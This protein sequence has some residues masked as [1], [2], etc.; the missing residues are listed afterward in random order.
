M[1]DSR[2][3]VEIMKENQQQKEVS[4]SPKALIVPADSPSP[5]RAET[6]L[7]TVTVTPSGFGPP[8][9]ARGRK[10]IHDNLYEVLSIFSHSLSF[11]CRLLFYLFYFIIFFD[12]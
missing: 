7:T 1:E 12:F 11:C 3:V 4:E 6:A 8:D 10:S 2:R 9:T 5:S